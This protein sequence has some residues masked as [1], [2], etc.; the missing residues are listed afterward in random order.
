MSGNAAAYG[1]GGIH[2]FGSGA[3][4]PLTNS[5]VSGNAA[6]Y[7]GGGIVNRSTD[8]S[9]T[10]SR[11]LVSGNTVP[12]TAEVSVTSR[13]SF[14]ATFTLLGHKGLTTAA[15]LAGFTPDPSDI[16]AT[17]DG[18]KPTALTDILD[19]TLRDNG[20]PTLTLNL[21]AGSPAIDAAGAT[22]GLTTDQR[23]AP[24]PVDGNGVA[25]CDIGAVEFGSVPSLLALPLPIAEGRH[26][27][28]K[29]R[30]V[31]Q[32]KRAR[33]VEIKGRCL[34]RRHARKQRDEPGKRECPGG[35]RP[36]I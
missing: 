8:P 3:R 29:S 17:S 6:A 28:G 2:N 25:G 13:S 7:G 21:V 14:T 34:I 32:P 12:T 31:S 18:N 9:L 27:Q 24:R 15:A 4:L 26:V 5:T 36:H 22:C 33:N 11:S 30:R 16:V 20:G 10:L 35:S 1:G 19:T 23:G